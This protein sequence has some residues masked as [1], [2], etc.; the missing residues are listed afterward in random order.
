MALNQTTPTGGSK[1]VHDPSGTTM[2]I[3]VA[4]TSRPPLPDRHSGVS[5]STVVRRRC[6]IR[7]ATSRS[8]RPGPVG[9]DSARDVATPSTVAANHAR[10][11]RMTPAN[12]T[13]PTGTR[14]SGEV[15]EVVASGIPRLLVLVRGQVRR[16]SD[17]DGQTGH[18]EPSRRE[19][20]ADHEALGHGE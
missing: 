1:T 9:L 5:A 6:R 7:R 3:K 15:A 11:S 2:T 18:D 19:I 17:V 8:G 20:E 13:Q 14:V 16:A 10:P 12:T 4:M